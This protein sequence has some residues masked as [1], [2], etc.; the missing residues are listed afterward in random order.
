MSMKDQGYGRNP[1]PARQDGAPQAQRPQSPKRPAQRMR[2]VSGLAAGS[3]MFAR[4]PAYTPVTRAPAPEPYAEP[5]YRQDSYQRDPYQQDPY[6]QENYGREARQPRPAQQPYGQPGYDEHGYEQPYQ[7]DAGY[8]AE[9][10]GGYAE[11]DYQNGQHLNGNGYQSSY[12]NGFDAEAGGYNGYAADAYQNGYQNGGLQDASFGEEEEPLDL[13]LD[14]SGAGAVGQSFEAYSGD[15]SMSYDESGYE[16]NGYAGQGYEADG[17]DANGYDANGYDANGYD[18]NGYDANGYDANGY[19][20]KAHGEQAYDQQAYAG[21]YRGEQSYGAG[22]DGYGAGAFGQGY[23][24]AEFGAQGYPQ[25]DYGQANDQAYDPHH[26]LQTFDAPYDQAP[27]IALGGGRPGHPGQADAQFYESEQVDADFLDDGAAGPAKAKKSLLGGRSMVMVSSVLVGALALGGALAFAYKETGGGLA[28][29]GQP[30][31][32]TADNAPVKEAPQNTA[33]GAT[34]EKH[35]LIYD[36]LQNDEQTEQDHLVPRQEQLALPNMPAATDI[37]GGATASTGAPMATGST[38]NMSAPAGDD[39]ARKV[40][41]LVVRPDGSVEQ[42]TMQ[43][44]AAS[45]T[46]PAAAATQPAAAP[47]PAPKPTAEVSHKYVVQ[48][49]SKKDQTEALASFADMQQKY[50]SLLSNYRPMVQRVNLG[51][52]GVWYRLQIGPMADRGSASKLCS[53]LKSQGLNDCLVMT[54]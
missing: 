25:Q 14:E 29:G 54:Q 5:D 4:M 17:Y 28:S 16:P 1:F 49:A 32:I 35:K 48:V 45:A 11:Q 39:S 7:G 51:S 46:A 27:Q 34:P 13:E 42:P 50:P 36:R 30:P 47:A 43:T 53:Q 19:E 44:A 41:T 33:N 9:D 40:K 24:D 52:K 31:L 12:Q 20:T 15:A 23:E 26:A 6:Q 2:P 3:S 21:D 10:D 8:A 37:P 18:A 22:E 38:S